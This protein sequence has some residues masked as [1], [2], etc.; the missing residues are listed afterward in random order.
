L[1]R[2]FHGKTENRDES[3]AVIISHNEP[4]PEAATYTN[5]FLDK[6]IAAMIVA[7]GFH[8]IAEAN[9][10]LIFHETPAV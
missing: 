10:G 6:R 8:D 5:V 7:D 3:G 1:G 2:R 9:V 4:P